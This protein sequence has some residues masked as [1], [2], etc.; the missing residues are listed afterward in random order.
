MSE[1]EDYAVGF[2]V[3]GN[4]EIGMGHIYR[5]RKIASLLKA[6]NMKVY[7]FT[8]CDPNNVELLKKCSDEIFFIKENVSEIEFIKFKIK[9]LRIKLFVLDKLNTD[10]SY[11]SSVKES[12]KVLCLDD[13]GIGSTK[14]DLVINGIV[15]SP[16]TQTYEHILFGPKYIILNLPATISPIKIINKKVA[17][18]LL[19]FGG[20]DP[21]NITLYALNNL[22]D[23]EDI[24]IT[25]CIGPAFKK[26]LV[27][28]I[29]KMIDGHKNINVIRVDDISSYI[30]ESDLC[31]VSGGITLFEVAYLGVPSIVICQVDHQ[32]ETAKLFEANNA[33]LNLGLHSELGEE[34]L[35]QEFFNIINDYQRREELSMA[36]KLYV[37]G[38]GIERIER[39]IIKILKE[40]DIC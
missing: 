20:S 5:V 7:I 14:A 36:S 35:K 29:N 27:D 28:T 19:S 3:D 24:E 4:N 22:I 39:E 15:R 13:N 12:C 17:K 38:K 25:V 10:I 2:R 33:C 40:E 30:I 6:N 31:I 34:H 37:D 9:Y 8:K 23:L 18:V 1:K 11:I 21:N 16:Y 26:T 32:V